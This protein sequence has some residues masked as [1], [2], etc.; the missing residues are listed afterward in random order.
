MGKSAELF[1]PELL[2]AIPQRPKAHPEK[3]GGSG[4]VVAGLLERFDDGVA[5]DALKLAP[6]GGVPA[7]GGRQ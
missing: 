2:D 5:L 4:L 1:N 7:G 3:L 6:Q